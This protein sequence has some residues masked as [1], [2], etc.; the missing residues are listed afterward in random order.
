MREHG[1]RRLARQIITVNSTQCPYCLKTYKD[2][3][4]VLNHLEYHAKRC[5]RKMLEALGLPPDGS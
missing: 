4:T 1:K 2:H 5:H 3:T